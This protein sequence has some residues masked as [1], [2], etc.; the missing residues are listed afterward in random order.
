LDDRRAA[1]LV[2]VTAPAGYGK[3]TLLAQWAERDAR[4]VVW[5]TLR[6]SDRDPT[7]LSE[8]IATAL[9]PA[10]LT[11]AGF[12]LVIDDAHLGHPATLKDTALDMLTWL[13]DGSQVAIAGRCA[14]PLPVDRMRGQRI[15][16]ELGADELAM[17]T[18]EAV[19][20]LRTIGLDLGHAT[21]QE[22]VRRTEGWPVLLELAAESA[23]AAP[24][25]AEA[26]ARLAGDD[27]V[28]SSYFRAELLAGLSPASVRFL[29]RGAV[30]ERV[31]GPLCDAV[32]E[33]TRSAGVLARLALSNVPLRAADSSHEWYRL[34]GLFREM[35][36]TEL[37][38]SEPELMPALY[39]RAGDWHT[40]AGELDRAIE[41]ARLSGSLDRTGD[42]LWANL[43]RF[44]GDGRNDQVQRWL[45]GVTA[46]QAATCAPLALAAAHS[47]LAMGNIA[48]AEQWAR[49][50]TVAL[51]GQTPASD[52][53]QRAG[54][55]LIDG[56]A[57]RSGTGRMGGDAALA[58]E[59]LP[60]DSVW[61]ADCCFLQGVARLLTG[62]HS[63]A[64]RHLDE[65][66]VRGAV[67][68]PD[69]ES[70]CLAQLAVLALEDDD[71]ELAD[72]LAQR[73]RAAIKGRDLRERPT[74]TLVF[75]VS[76][77]AGVSQGRVDEANAAAATCSSGIAASDGF[78]P[79]Y[80]A[81]TRILLARA[82]LALGDVPGARQQLADASRLARRTP[83]VVVF[84][85]W[86][87]DMWEQFD[88][89]AEAALVGVGSL[90]T[91]ELRVLR[92][93][94]THFSFHEIAERLHV[95]SNTVK[96]HVHAVYRKL[97]ASSRS[98]AVAHAT[99][100]GLLGS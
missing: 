34:H 46:E 10:G 39:R 23:A 67:I 7:V 66:A 89:R 1:P 72:D 47:A 98:E 68:A 25:P 88:R 36:M 16:V 78:A 54:A 93:L 5:L 31:S 27:H 37:R 79:W 43:P 14:P 30:L 9:R 82:L 35:L 63:A 70:L 17:S 13:P 90:T 69:M 53:R 75:A 74:L 77:A 94:P 51:S 97:D 20:L 95:S 22:I 45:A 29:T 19:S 85:R 15:L 55:L 62:D 83:G 92:F 42:L 50:A 8:S 81:E 21:I 100:A 73:A 40:R 99:S 44:L 58:Y 57:A 4:P 6:E 11:H 52:D 32:L 76:A 56:W 49:S 59:L 91:A 3:T 28:I 86:F 41:D 24:D 61:R 48:V 96:T 64:A 65:G 60:G 12:L 87:E 26:L 18:V 38:R 84:Q 80:G 2:L 33:R 71:P